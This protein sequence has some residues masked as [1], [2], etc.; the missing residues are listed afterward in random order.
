[1]HL[2]RSQLIRK[3]NKGY[4]SLKELT[5]ITPQQQQQNRTQI[6]KH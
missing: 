4:F 5:E 1:M 6:P 3:Y 2:A